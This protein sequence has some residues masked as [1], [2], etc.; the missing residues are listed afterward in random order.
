MLENIKVLITIS[1][2]ALITFLSKQLASIL[3]FQGSI[4]LE[5]CESIYWREDLICSRI[6]KIKNILETKPLQ[7]E[8]NLPCL[9]SN[10]KLVLMG[11]TE[12]LQE[13]K[14]TSI[15]FTIKSN[16]TNWL[17]NLNLVFWI[18]LC[19]YI[20]LTSC[21]HGTI[22]KERNKIMNVLDAIC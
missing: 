13:Y 6:L 10:S 12:L 8:P 20:Y 16:I 15:P 17:L 14:N 1:S 11:S 21:C 9:N 19:N 2:R 5:V 3:L 18:V 4:G 22:S 7:V